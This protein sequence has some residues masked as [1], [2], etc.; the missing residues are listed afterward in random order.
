M[1]VIRYRCTDCDRNIELIERPESLE[2]IGR[3]IV[4]NKCTG[5]L[6][7]VERL[8]DYAVGRFPEDVTGLTNWI[9][10]NVVYD[11]TQAIADSIWTVTHNLGVNPSVQV[12]VDREE[13]VDGVVTTSRIEIQ[14]ETVTIVDENTLTLTFDR[15]ESGLAQIVAR[16][17][18]A[19]EIVEEADP[20][21]T[22]LPVTVDGIMTLGIDIASGQFPATSDTTCTVRLYF[23]DQEDL[24]E[25]ALETAV[26]NDYEVSTVVDSSSAWSD[27]SEI[28]VNGNVYTIVTFDIGDPV[29][30]IN[31]PSAGA[32]LFNAGTTISGFPYDQA[33]NTV[34]ML[35]SPPHLDADKNRNYIFRPDL[36]VGPALTLDSFV[37]GNGEISV[38][39]LKTEK[40]FPPVYTITAAQ[41][42]GFVEPTPEPDGAFVMAMGAFSGEGALAEGVIYTSDDDID[43]WTGIRPIPGSVTF[44]SPAGMIYA[45]SIDTWVAIPKRGSSTESIIYSTDDGVTWNISSV[46]PTATATGARDKNVAWSPTLGLF[47]VGC[48][49]GQI[50]YSSD[51]D[52]WTN[53]TPGVFGSQILSVH[54]SSTLGVFMASTIDN[55]VGYSANGTSWT[56]VT[57]EPG[58][59]SSDDLSAIYSI[60]SR[61]FVSNNVDETV[62]YSD[63][64]TG[65]GT[66]TQATVDIK[67][68]FNA[69]SFAANADGS[70]LL[71]AGPGGNDGEYIWRSTDNGENFTR[72]DALSSLG[73]TGAFSYCVV[74][75]SDYG[76]M[77]GGSAAIGSPLYHFIASSD[78]GITWTLRLAEKFV[79]DVAAVHQIAT[80]A[81]KNQTIDI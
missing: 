36:E 32:V 41:D 22:Y 78:D 12:I 46:I 55:E 28:F 47:I 43:T 53:A 49:S 19:T 56:L 67:P 59:S 18:R 44:P 52:T 26:F 37:F 31:A 38:D 34:V 16:S 45:E 73:L 5:T 20:G 10:R 40:A 27:A 69:G 35:S 42:K 54:W 33:P 62:Y 77:V 48:N 57:T 13:T 68:T 51:G 17:T 29:N 76:F 81:S 1:A 80:I 70:V 79:S 30:Q 6:Y 7:R 14:P 21:T 4:T 66:W 3:C 72:L 58:G 64:L 39:E 74:H 71:W 61:V 25:T 8:E 23:L 60:G 75:D 15:P 50:I 11:H 63:N 24:T 65:A 9:Q 2:T